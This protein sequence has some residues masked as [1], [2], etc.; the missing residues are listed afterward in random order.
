M[1]VAFDG[2]KNLFIQ[3]ILLY[4][5]CVQNSM[6]GSV[7]DICLYTTQ[8]MFFRNFSRNKNMY[9]SVYDRSTMAGST[10]RRNWCVAYTLKDK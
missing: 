3:G 9:T 7:K 8:C 1:K 2:L 6:V 5:Y 10:L 4:T